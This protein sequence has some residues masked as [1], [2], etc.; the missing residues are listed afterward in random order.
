MARKPVVV[1][2]VPKVLYHVVR[3]VPGEHI[4]DVE[5]IDGTVLMAAAEAKYWIDQGVLATVERK[6]VERRRSERKAEAER[7]PEH[8]GAH[9]VRPARTNA[10]RADQLSKPK[11]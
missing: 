9:H 10:D 11:P 3:D 6:E 7:N 5:I 4:G 8:T 1:R 2:D